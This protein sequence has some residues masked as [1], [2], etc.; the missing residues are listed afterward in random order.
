MGV[1]GYEG[2]PGLP[3]YREIR[4]IWD[5]AA[6]R[7]GLLK[8]GGSN[9]HGPGISGEALG[10]MTISCGQVQA[11]QRLLPAHSVHHS[12]LKRMTWRMANLSP[13]EFKDSLF[14]KKISPR[15]LAC[16]HL[17]NQGQP[18]P[19]PPPDF[20]G[21]P[22]VLIG[23]AAISKTSL[24]LEMLRK[25]ECR[26]LTQISRNDFPDLTWR[27]YNLDRRDPGE[28]K[29]ELL[30]FTLDRYLYRKSA[31]KCR[32][33]FFQNKTAVSLRRLK[34]TIRS[35]LGPM[36]FYQLTCEGLT[37][38]FFTSFIHMPDEE[39]IKNESWKLLQLG[40]TGSWIH[41]VAS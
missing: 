36:R 17:L 41:G 39:M 38:S 30:R 18:L 3:K 27:I 26:V 33:V 35:S 23:P 7:N 10:R 6:E 37:D 5:N 9:F 25:N 11:I 15:N 21:A 31:A 40:C 13:V 2:L 29:K 34:Q 20:K 16:G 8:L 19:E 12:F 32:I 24:I 4:R 14:P 22:Y 1:I 28:Q